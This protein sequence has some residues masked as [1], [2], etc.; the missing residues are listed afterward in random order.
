MSSKKNILHPST[1]KT[2][3]RVLH[4]N[5]GARLCDVHRSTSCGFLTLFLSAVAFLAC[6]VQIPLLAQANSAAPAA[7][8]LPQIDPALAAERFD[9]ATMAGTPGYFR[10]GRSTTGHWWF[11]DPEGQPFFYRGVTSVSRGDDLDHPAPYT[12]RVLELYGRSPEGFRKITFERLRS[13]GFN[14]LGAWS[15]EELWNQG[16]PFTVILNFAQSGPQIEG[17]YLPDV[18]DPAWEKGI[19]ARARK[20]AAPQ[21]T[22][23]QLIGYFTDNEL[24]WEQ[25]PQGGLQLA[26]D[27]LD[28]KHSPTLLQLCLS[29]QPGKAAY[30][31]AWSFVLAR[32][33]NS[34]Q[35]LAAAWNVPLE[36]KATVAQ[37]TRKQTAIRSQEYLKD[38]A[39]FSGDFARRYFELTAKA[40]RKYDPNH[41]ILGCRF[42]GPPG[43]AVLAQVKRPWVDVVSANNYRYEMQARMNIYYRAT[44][45]PVMNTEFSW[46]HA[47][48][49]E[50]PLPNENP[51]GATAVERMVANGETAL[52]DSFRLSGLVGWT[53]YRWVD[54][55]DFVPPITYGLV[56]IGN[57]PN[58]ITTDLA[59]RINRCAER[60]AVTGACG[61]RVKELAVAPLNNRTSEGAPAAQ[62]GAPALP[63]ARPDPEGFQQRR[64]LMLQTLAGEDST[65]F[66]KIK[67]VPDPNKYALPTVLA[68]ME[69]KTDQQGANAYLARHTDELYNFS[70]VGLTR[71]LG[72]YGNRIPAETR[73]KIEKSISSTATWTADGTE[74]HKLMWLTSG[75]ALASQL[76][77]LSFWGG[78][79]EWRRKQLLEPIRLYVKRLYEVGEGEWDSSTYVPFGIQSFVNLYDFSTDPH[80]R[81]VAA[82][83]LDWY[84]TALAL[85]YFHGTLAGAE[86]R[87]FD[88]GTFHTDA[89]LAGWLWWGDS[90]RPA[91]AEDFTG[92]RAINGRYSI[93]AALSG[94]RPHPALDEL[95]RKTSPLAGHET[96]P[97][98]GMERAA[99]N[100]GTFV[101]TK[102]YF[103]GSME[104]GARGLTPWENQI[105]PWKLVA[106]G[107][108]ENYSFTSLNPLLD[109]N[110]GRSPYDQVAQYKS[111]LIQMTS[112]P[113]DAEGAIER[114]RDEVTHRPS[115]DDRFE[116]R[117]VREARFRLPAS[118][119]AVQDHGWFFIEAGQTWV[120]VHPLLPGAT[121][122]AV[123]GKS[124]E[125]YIVSKGSTTGFV[126][127]VADRDSYPTMQAFREAVIRIATP[128]LSDI[129]KGHL[130]VNALDGAKLDFTFNRSGTW[131][132]LLVNGEA[133][134]PNLSKVYDTPSVQQEGGRL[135]VRNSSGA[136]F[137]WDFTG[138]W[139]YYTELQ[140]AGAHA[141]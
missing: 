17:T 51:M 42:G 7:L 61:A 59:T 117:V 52:E 104:I 60:I 83:A 116:G 97:N 65:Y 70:V 46:G 71:L 13:W 27:A 73:G 100:Y 135:T 99:Q 45:L 49:S 124:A 106:R 24:G 119:D 131:P 50:R 114:L 77:E 41:L 74:N 115:G 28:P 95:V 102:N 79:A 33:G 138:D 133:Q 35:K 54:K 64:E 94:Y 18:F 40:I 118:L 130:Q 81:A 139:P 75:E 137:Q 58:S 85:K 126:V 66:E 87:G 68:K 56:T 111:T 23:K 141:K 78:A 132:A 92:P 25:M 15:N 8:E 136:G 12:K 88:D 121:L 72:M 134:K 55:V 76:P 57:D 47:G 86:E 21:R 93:Y 84:S 67:R 120:A 19:D 82:A 34:L 5:A 80:A 62:G 63:D 37:W 10:V 123:A 32:H 89:A 9:P 96:K 122:E 101:S 3:S 1:S 53:W 11:Q 103:L 98:Y 107:A 2:H 127:Q 22:S 128:E 125:K 36:D 48:F 43:D 29:Q 129:A 30:E 20:V 140:G 16:M 91:T 26:S 39:Q 108:A 69:E 113:A 90:T 105:C 44:G 38:D 14:A 31:A 110:E 4:N 6:G 112:V 109:L